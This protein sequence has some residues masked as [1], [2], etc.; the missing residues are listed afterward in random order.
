MKKLMSFIPNI[1]TLLNMTF[2]IISILYTTIL[3]TKEEFLIIPSVLIILAFICDFFDGNIARRLSAVSK[4]GKELDSLSDLVSFGIAPAIVMF[5]YVFTGQYTTQT[6]VVLGVIATVFFTLCG[7][8]RLARFNSVEF[9][10]YF[11]GLPIPVG[12]ALLTI[13]VIVFSY[14]RRFIYAT[15]LVPILFILISLVI[16]YLMVSDIKVKKL[17]ANKDRG[18][19]G[20]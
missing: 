15:Y 6:F 4:I 10:T 5:K 19:T 20:E 13:S 9:D 3:T 12:G 2:G 11:R 7:A 1:L 16:G 18:S 8:Y 14:L 17:F